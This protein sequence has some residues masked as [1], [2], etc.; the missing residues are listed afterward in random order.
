M[1]WG[2]TPEESRTP[3][4][5]GSRYRQTVWE[6]QNFHCC[7][8]QQTVGQQRGETD[9]A[10]STFLPRGDGLVAGWL[11]AMAETGDELLVD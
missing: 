5:D 8:T 9:A 7:R 2:K 6:S 3:S 4:C 1:S 10:G 11:V